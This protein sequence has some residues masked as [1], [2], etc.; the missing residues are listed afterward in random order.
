VQVMKALKPWY[1]ISAPAD[2]DSI[3]AIGAVDGKGEIAKFSSF[4]PN[5]SGRVKPDVCAQGAGT[6]VFDAGGN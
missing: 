3:L 5:A 2:A 1:Y 6:A 4:G